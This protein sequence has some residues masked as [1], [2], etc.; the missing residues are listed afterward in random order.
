M[1]LG[2]L[3][4]PKMGTLNL[5]RAFMYL[6]KSVL[7]KEK[8]KKRNKKRDSAT[9]K[10]YDYPKRHANYGLS[11]PVSIPTLGEFLTQVCAAQIAQIKRIYY[12]LLGGAW[13]SAWRRPHGV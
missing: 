7:V 10:A 4:E 6:E 8:G 3:L 11:S 2:N 5:I 12:F 9:E 13:R 1:F